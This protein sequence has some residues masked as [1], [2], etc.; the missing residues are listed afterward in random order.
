MSWIDRKAKREQAQELIGKAGAILER[1]AK[2]EQRELT[3]EENQEFDTLHHE[4]EKILAEV[5]QME[6]QADAEN[7]IGREPIETPE[8]ADPHTFERFLR[9]GTRPETRTLTKGT[10]TEGAEFV[11]D[12]FYSKYEYYLRE[13]D[14]LAAAGAEIIT[15]QN[16]QD[17]PVPTFD[18][19]SNTGELLAEGSPSTRFAE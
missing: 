6:R 8:P 17:L 12:D 2:V 9:T 11:P 15:T 5:R 19:S 10:A 18:D 14:T 16:G 1:A 4:A 13:L 3:D 7:L